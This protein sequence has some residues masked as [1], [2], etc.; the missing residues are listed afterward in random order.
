M[1]GLS[2]L[3]ML[4]LTSVAHADQPQVLIDVQHDAHRQ[5]TCWI[6]PQGGISCLPDSQIR[7]V[8]PKPKASPASGPAPQVHQEVFQL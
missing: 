4:A 5:V 7:Q 8:T 2:L 1:R 3:L 6:T